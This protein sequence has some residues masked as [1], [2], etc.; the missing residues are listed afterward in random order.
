MESLY[1]NVPLKEALKNAL[2]KQCSHTEPPEFPRSTMKC[3]FQQGMVC[4]EEKIGY[5]CI[6]GS[7]LDNF[8][9]K[10]QENDLAMDD[11]QKY[12]IL[13]VV[14]FKNGKEERQLETRQWKVNF[15]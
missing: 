9:L 2:E 3:L 1:K 6:P 7:Q 14:N 5:G 13:K 8:S 12:D 15:V 11:P 4:T 10:N